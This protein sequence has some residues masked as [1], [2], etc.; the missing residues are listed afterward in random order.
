MDSATLLRWRQAIDRRRSVRKFTGESLEPGIVGELEQLCETCAHL[1]GGGVRVVLVSGQDAG[2]R[3]FHWL[4][5]GMATF[6]HRSSLVFAILSSGLPHDPEDA[7]FCGEQVVLD[8][9]S[10]GVGTCWVSGTF[11]RK[12][13]LSL[14]GAASSEHVVCVVA[15]GWPD[16][17][18]SVRHKRRKPFSRICD[19]PPDAL[20][21]WMRGA[22]NCVQLAPSGTNLQ[23]WWFEV[24]GRA[25]CTPEVVLWPR[26]PGWASGG[27]E[28]GPRRIDRG[29]AMLHFSVGASS[30]GADG[31]WRLD[32]DSDRGAVARF[33]VEG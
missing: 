5:G 24:R 4:P 14:A 8:A 2:R 21:G 30:G 15:A 11:S 3:I 16:P 1:P 10:R 25:S 28:I 29:I 12:A 26:K 23:P 6:I 19:T 13:A 18:A 33:S 22:I 31:R 9:C 32:S 7:G 20:P 17:G 27:L